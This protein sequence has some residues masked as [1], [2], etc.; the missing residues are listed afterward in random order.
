MSDIDDQHDTSQ[1]DT[2]AGRW[3]SS[4]G[5]L[6]KEAARERIKCPACLGTTTSVTIAWQ[7]DQ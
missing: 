6:F 5:D 4:D 1:S 3:L 7:V 2:I